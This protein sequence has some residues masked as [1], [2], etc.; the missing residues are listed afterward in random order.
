MQRVFLLLGLVLPWLSVGAAAAAEL[1][2]G[3]AEVDITAPAGYR[4]SGYFSERLNTGIHDPLKAKA[5][6]L[7]QGDQRAALV[8]CDL[9]GMPASVAKRAR[10]LAQAKAEAPG[11]HILIAAT[12]SHTGPLFYGTLREYFHR[13]ALEQK[14][15][16]AAESV[17]Y[18]AMLAEKLAQ[19]VA[20]ARAAA[21][22]GEL[23]AGVVEQPGLSFNRRF[24]MKDG[25]VVFNPGKLNPNIVRVAGPIDPQVGVLLVRDAQQQLGVLTAFA[26]HLDTIGGTEYSADYPF[27]LERELRA[28]LGPA[29]ISMFGNGTCGDINH[30]D[31]TNDRPQKGQPEAER[32]GVELSKTVLSALPGLKPLASP[33][34]A[35][36]SVKVNVPLQRYSPEQFAAAQAN[37][38]KV[39]TK[40]LSFL[41]QVEACKIVAIHSRGVEVLPL[42]VQI[43]R[44][45]PETAVVGLPGEVFVELGLAIKQASPF[46]VTMIVEL[47]N[48]NPHYVPTQ[49][50]FA[51]GSYETVNSIVQSG[52]GEMLVDAAVKLLKELKQ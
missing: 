16:D 31:V 5:L 14:G 41:E 25:R 12:H 3:V 35:V 21:K 32:I 28:K 50:A 44:L 49:K 42:E 52:G 13:R 4:M 34:L 38:A 9:I 26:L 20:A 27:Y 19:V 22:P 11:A 37:L 15:A 33:A 1:K 30:I 10:E 36:R 18:S 8:F 6:Y 29:L 48:D 51:E 47:S 17:D 45:D 23:S 43:F 39:G 46:P 2:V 40:E 24:H 7:E